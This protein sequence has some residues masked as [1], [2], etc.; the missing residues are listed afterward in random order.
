M[1]RLFYLAILSYSYMQV[2]PQGKVSF[3]SDNWNKIEEKKALKI[4][5]EI[6]SYIT[7]VSMNEE[8]TILRTQPLPFYKEYTIVEM[9]DMSSIPAVK[10]YAIYKQGDVNIIDWT[11]NVI[12]DVNQK[13]PIVLN[14]NN[15]IS[16]I[17]FFFSYVYGR[18][19]KFSVIEAVDDIKWQIDPPMQGRKIMQEMLSPVK[20]KTKNS[21]GSFDL[22]AFMVFKDSL[23]RTDIHVENDGTIDMSQ[24]ELKVEGMPVL[25]EIGF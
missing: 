16:Y 23:F 24:E 17:K 21:D 19:G 25:Q 9:T 12:Y 8:R 5:Q 14:E 2:Y 10:K 18:H 15:I 13:V 20:I 11:N 4:L 1:H 7:P 22:E 3:M 6:N